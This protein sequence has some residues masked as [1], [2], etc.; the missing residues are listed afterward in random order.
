MNVIFKLESSSFR[1][2]R[3]LQELNGKPVR[4]ENSLFLQIG[5]DLDE[6]VLD[7]DVEDFAGEAERPELRSRS[8]FW[9]RAIEGANFDKLTCIT[10]TSLIVM[11]KATSFYKKNNKDCFEMIW[12]FSIS[13]LINDM[14]GEDTVCVADL[15]VHNKTY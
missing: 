8:E 13:A 7:I 5:L 10:H 6:V 12:L 11:A 1:F 4:D 9:R 14:V 3:F 2:G 15:D